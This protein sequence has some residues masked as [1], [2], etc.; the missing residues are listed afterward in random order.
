MKYLA[1]NKATGQITGPHSE[2]YKVAIESNPSTRG[3]YDWIKQPESDA[4]TPDS[5]TKAVKPA[6]KKE[7]EGTSADGE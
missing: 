7:A 5:I 6:K 3:R 2:E 4:V 1:R